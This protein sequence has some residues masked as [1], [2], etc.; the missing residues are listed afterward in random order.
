MDLDSERLI[1]CYSGQIQELNGLQ[2]ELVKRMVF[3]AQNKTNLSVLNDYPNIQELSLVDH[4]VGVDELS[5]LK[6]LK[7]LSVWLNKEQSW[8]QVYLPNL[9]SLQIHGKHNGDLTSLLAPIKYLHLDNMS[10]VDDLSVYLEPVQNLQKLYISS[11]SSLIKLPS[12]AQHQNLYALKLYE[13][14]KLHD[15]SAL[16]DS[17]LLYIAASL[18]ADKLSASALAQAMICIPNL[19]GAALEYVDRSGRRYEEIKKVFTLNHKEHLLKP[20]LSALNTWLAL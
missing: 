19:K 10:K 5:N 11:I 20:K 12:L 4:C 13:L 14:H 8:N 9:D 15:L 18:I 17:H 16:S 7:S 3:V 2:P 1:F 6:Q